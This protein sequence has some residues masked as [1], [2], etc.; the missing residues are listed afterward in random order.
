ME[1]NRRLI[2]LF[3]QIAALLGEKGETFKANAYRKAAQVLEDLQK[4]VSEIGDKKQLMEL[5]GIGDAIADKILEFLETGKIQHLENL[6]VEQGDLPMELLDV[7]DLGPKRIREMQKELGIQT[8]A[9]LIKAAEAGKLRSLPRLSEHMEQKILENARRV[10][11]RSKRYPREEVVDDVENILAAIRSVP[12]VEKAEVGGSYR[13]HK[14]TVGDI[15]I[16]VVT[17]DPERVIDAVSKLSI[18]KQV[19]AKG[20]TKL[21]FNLESLL[22]VDV[23]F[24]GADEWGS[25][26]LYFTGDKEHNISLRRRAI[27]RGWKLNEYSLSEGNRIIAQKTE[28]DIYRALDLPWIDPTERKAQLS[29]V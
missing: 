5:P 19:V 8:V 18:V 26:L 24:V 17:S 28:E 11:E 14:S 10:A 13:R 4:D 2:H 16:L 21:S 29:V 7:E 9:D 12:G 23:R 25:A 3:H 22:R 6:R 1:N 20:D 15:D 27:E